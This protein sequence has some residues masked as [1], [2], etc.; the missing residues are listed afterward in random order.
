LKRVYYIFYSKFLIEERLLMPK[1][2]NTEPETT[3]EATQE[4]TK[5]EATTDL[6]PTVPASLEAISDENKAAVLALSRKFSEKKR[7]FHADNGEGGGFRP[8]IVKIKQPTTSNCPPGINNGEMFTN[9]NEVIGK[10]LQLI[11]L[12]FWRERVKWPD[13]DSISEQPQ[14]KSIDGVRGL[15]RGTDGEAQEWRECL[16]CPYRK[17]DPE[18]NR[19]PCKE[20]INVLG[21]DG[22][23]EDF[24]RVQFSGTSAKVGKKFYNAVKGH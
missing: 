14:C 6:V 18:E 22:V 12:N 7:G 15:W 9:T 13:G 10:E 5:D 2:K 11:P 4:A 8:Q 17:W 19:Y 21:V 16:T 24:Y 20:S 3:Q 23:L 1:T